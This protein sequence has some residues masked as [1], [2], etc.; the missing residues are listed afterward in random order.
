VLFEKRNINTIIVCCHFI[1]SIFSYSRDL[2]YLNARRD[3][4]E[5]TFRVDSTDTALHLA[6]LLAHAELGTRSSD[7]F[8]ASQTTNFPSGLPPA[9]NYSSCLPP[10]HRTPE[11][12]D[13]VDRSCE[14]LT[15][16]RLAARKM[17]LREVVKLNSYGEHLHHA[18]IEE[19]NEFVHISVGPK[20][21]TLFNHIYLPIFWYI[22]QLF[23][24]FSL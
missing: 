9:T 1:F 10:S 14:L 21:I 22:C 8:N 20:G 15:V 19:L 12:V 6:A 7:S 18:H 16:S 2:F 11:N 17:F 5:E 23:I 4:L 24:I 13:R 3:F